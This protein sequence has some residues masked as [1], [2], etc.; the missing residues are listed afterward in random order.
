[1]RIMSDFQPSTPASPQTN[2]PPLHRQDRRRQTV[3]RPRDRLSRG[4]A[5]PEHR[6]WGYESAGI[7]AKY[8][9][10]RS[11]IGTR[12]RECHCYKLP[13]ACRIIGP[14]GPARERRAPRKKKITKKKKKRERSHRLDLPLPTKLFTRQALTRW[15]SASGPAEHGRTPGGLWARGPVGNPPGSAAE[16]NSQRLLIGPLGHRDAADAR[17]ERCTSARQKTR[18]KKPSCA[19]KQPTALPLHA[20]ASFANLEP[21]TSRTDA[22]AG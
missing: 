11:R 18:G 4:L 6:R 14:L 21:G 19:S 13:W 20:L 22:M 1:M 5:D 3:S 15:G 12:L 16:R 7:Q 9:P 2:L 10:H 17:G 8:D